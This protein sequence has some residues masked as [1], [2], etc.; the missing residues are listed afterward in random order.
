MD[1]TTDQM[2]KQLVEQ[3]SGLLGE[4]DTVDATLVGT[5]LFAVALTQ[6]GVQA[7]LEKINDNLTEINDHLRN[8]L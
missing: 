5:G 3:I 4:A 1:A 2:A 8:R 7:T 6:M